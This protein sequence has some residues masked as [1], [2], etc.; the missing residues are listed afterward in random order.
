MPANIGTF[1]FQNKSFINIYAS[2]ATEIS[3]CWVKG[4]VYPIYNL[5]RFIYKQTKRGQN[6]KKQQKILWSREEKTPLSNMTSM[7]NGKMSTICMRQVG[8][9]DLVELSCHP[10]DVFSNICGEVMFCLLFGFAIGKIGGIKK[11]LMLGLFLCYWWNN[12][13][14]PSDHNSHSLFINPCALSRFLAHRCICDPIRPIPS[15]SNRA[16]IDARKRSSLVFIQ[17]SVQKIT[18]EI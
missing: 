13:H 2:A 8:I 7:L 6:F 9:A 17:K 1:L 14:H 5:Y 3:S 4:V 11:Q 16:F 12:Y 10:T 18:P 15:Q